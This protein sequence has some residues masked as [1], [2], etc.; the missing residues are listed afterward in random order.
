M[1]E[2]S[3]LTYTPSDPERERE[4][5]RQAGR[6]AGRG[7]LTQTDRDGETDIGRQRQTERVCV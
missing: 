6:Q 3:P 4:R 7:R 2:L 1:Y 5:E